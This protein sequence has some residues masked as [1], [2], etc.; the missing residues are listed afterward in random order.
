MGIESGAG[1]RFPIP[2]V[3]RTL[4]Y[5]LGLLI[6][7]F[8]GWSWWDSTLR[9][10]AVAHGSGGQR[11]VLATCNGTVRFLRDRSALSGSFPEPWEAVH[12]DKRFPNFVM[13]PGIPGFDALGLV[14]PPRYPMPSWQAGESGNYSRECLALPHWLLMAGVLPLWLAALYWSGRKKREAKTG[15]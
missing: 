6:L 11:L 15:N 12:R 4:V 8:L 7:S 9:V 3:L 13:F 14:K 10:A 5:T 1:D 2:C